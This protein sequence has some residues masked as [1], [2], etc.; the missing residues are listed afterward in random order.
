MKKERV[1][2]PEWACILAGL[3]DSTDKL[4]RNDAG[5][6]MADQVIDLSSFVRSAL[7]EDSACTAPI[8]VIP[9]RS[10]SISSAP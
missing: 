5:L 8:A 9:F 7:L 6:M 3:S 1:M 2:Q 10:P 4:A